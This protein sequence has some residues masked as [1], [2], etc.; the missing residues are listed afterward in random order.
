MID[1]FD[2]QILENSKKI[3]KS[4][5][6]QYLSYRQSVKINDE[7]LAKCALEEDNSN[8]LVK[9]KRQANKLG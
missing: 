6:Y 5:R 1:K 8:K 3:G 9:E 2:K 7:L 4:S